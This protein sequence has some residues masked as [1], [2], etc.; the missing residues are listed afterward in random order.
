MW[1][2]LWSW[3]GYKP[4]LLLSY[5]AY[6]LYMNIPENGFLTTDQMKGQCGIKEDNRDKFVEG[7]AEIID[8]G[9]VNQLWIYKETAYKTPLDIQLDHTT[10]QEEVHCGFSRK[11][12]T[13]EV[14]W[15][16][17]NR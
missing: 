6:I 8:R 11:D 5:Y 10:P 14:N 16:E 4:P 13:L 9:L 7:L 3:L 2:W 17:D 1:N 15:V 12:P